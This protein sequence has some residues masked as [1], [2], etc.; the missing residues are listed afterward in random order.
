[1]TLSLDSL[2]RSIK[3]RLGG[4]Q[5]RLHVVASQTY[6][7]LLTDDI[8]AMIFEF[9]S[10]PPYAG[11]ASSQGIARGLDYKTV[12]RIS[13]VSRRFRNIALRL[14]G[15]W[16]FIDLGTQ[17]SSDV[18]LLV[19][20][21]AAAGPILEVHMES[22]ITR[23]R[24]KRAEELIAH[25]DWIA[26]VA[27][28]ITSI[29]LDFCLKLDEALL[30]SLVGHESYEWLSFPSLHELVVS[31]DEASFDTEVDFYRNWIVPNLKVLKSRNIIPDIHEEQLV[32]VS[33]CSLWIGSH[34]EP[35]WR[36]V[37]VIEFLNSLPNLKRLDISLHGDAFSPDDGVRSPSPYEGIEYLRIAFPGMSTCGMDNFLQC[38]STPNKRSWTHEFDDTSTQPLG[39]TL[40]SLFPDLYP[41]SILSTIAEGRVFS[42]K[43]LKR[44]WLTRC[45]ERNA[46]YNINKFTLIIRGESGKVDYNH[47]K[48]IPVHAKNLERFSVSYLSPQNRRFELMN[49]R[50]KVGELVDRL[51]GV[52]AQELKIRNSCLFID[53]S[54]IT[55]N[56][57]GELGAPSKLALTASTD[58]ALV[59]E[60]AD[61][62]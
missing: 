31:L 26:S 10:L 34:G 7:P 8:L 59:E 25:Y 51:D 38:F 20:R 5:S 57:A 23:D 39:G 60:V 33:D 2:I 4:L 29:R 15:L 30:S 52:L 14:P 49:C 24:K 32:G 3:D 55:Q 45:Q 44:H 54:S 62:E 50:G 28:R 48:R 37:T 11:T 13:Q 43:F 17:S 19:S 56:G 61:G 16:R 27:S 35:L 46:Y 41:H 22:Q 58:T 40:K 36:Y 47:L 21:N 9:A 42:A 1:M 18:Q 12:T 53:G 6:F